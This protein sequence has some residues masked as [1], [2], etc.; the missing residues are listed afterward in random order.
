M[1]CETNMRRRLSREKKHARAAR[2]MNAARPVEVVQREMDMQTGI[3]SCRR[4]PALP[5]DVSL[6]CMCSSQR[7]F[8][9]AQPP[10]V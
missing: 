1:E 5:R 4:S 8:G 10:V 9:T 7:Q 3:S 6:S 2:Q